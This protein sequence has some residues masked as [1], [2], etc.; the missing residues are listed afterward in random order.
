MTRIFLPLFLVLLAL[1]FLGWMFSD[2]LTYFVVSLV[3]ATLL[4]PLTGAIGSL[5]FYRM[6]MPRAMAVLAA[7]LTLTGVLALFVLTF[8]PLISDQVRLLAKTD[9]NALL[10]ELSSPLRAFEDFL[11]RNRL[12]YEQEGFLANAVRESIVRFFTS[13]NV[14]QVLNNLI[15]LTGS[16]FVSLLALVFITFFLLYEKGLLKRFFLRLIPN[17]YFELSLA[18]L[19][20]IE[21][22]LI[23]YL[24]GLLLQMMAIFAL[25][26]TGL[27]LMGIK[28]ALTIALFAALANLIPYLGPILGGT[29]GLLVGLSTAPD[30]LTSDGYFWLTIRIVAVFSVVQMVDNLLLQPLIFS[31]SVKAHPLEIFVIIFVGATLG[32]AVGMILAIPTYT[33]VRVFSAELYRGYQQ[34]SIFHI[35]Q[36][37]APL[38]P[39]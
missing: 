9:I 13:L 5:Q 6:R 29:F 28:Y 18:T 20:K 11:I 36:P 25:A 27:S 3:L 23:N 35:S 1:G 15:S 38:R 31:K 4:Q 17:A 24:S 12:T 10:L 34:Y 30:T 19:Y 2:I 39:K 32:G 33:V 22:L 21:R 8:L 37:S 26:A 14:N 7:F 16:I